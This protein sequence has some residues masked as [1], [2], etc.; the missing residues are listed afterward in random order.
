MNGTK[1]DTE[2][3]D[4]S[5]QVVGERCALERRGTDNEPWTKHK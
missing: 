3:A 1:Q 2:A 5:N 4:L